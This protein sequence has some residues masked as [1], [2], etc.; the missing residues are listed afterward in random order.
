[1]GGW[2]NRWI[3]MKWSR[4]DNLRGLFV[5]AFTLWVLPVMLMNLIYY[6][7]FSVQDFSCRILVVVRRSPYSTHWFDRWSLLF[8]MNLHVLKLNMKILCLSANIQPLNNSCVDSNKMF[9]LMQTSVGHKSCASG[10]TDGT[11]T[12]CCIHER[13]WL[14]WCKTGSNGK[15][16]N[17]HRSR[18]DQSGSHH[19]D[20]MRS[21]LLFSDSCAHDNIIISVELCAG[22]KGELETSCRTNLYQRSSCVLHFTFTLFHT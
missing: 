18:S 11:F 13:V 5:E 15:L 4:T 2:Q 17:D 14:V 21:L 7:L 8:Y 19:I 3:W 6:F 10:T 1:M 20:S 12:W 22:R 16:G 9:L